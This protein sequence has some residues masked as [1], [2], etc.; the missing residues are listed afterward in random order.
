MARCP[1]DDGGERREWGY[2]GETLLPAGSR[3]GV[4]SVVSACGAPAKQ[5]ESSACVLARKMRRVSR[6]DK[7]RR[8]PNDIRSIES[9]SSFRVP[10]D[11]ASVYAQR[12]EQWTQAV[13]IEFLHEREQAPYF[14]RRKPFA[15]EPIEVMAGQIGNESALVFAEW[16]GERHE[17]FEVV[18]IHKRE[19]DVGS[20]GHRSGAVRRVTDDTPM[21]C[22]DMKTGGRMRVSKKKMSHAP[23]SFDVRTVRVADLARVVPTHLLLDHGG[24][25]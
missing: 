18:R 21:R 22:H 10:N 6:I 11:S 5:S 24:I 15:C 8:N 17:A 25:T 9:N 7:L 16:H 20:R 1:P 19:R 3:A 13:V 12:I 14:S 2:P 23:N 4:A